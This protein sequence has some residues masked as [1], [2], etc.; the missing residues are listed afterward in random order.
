MKSAHLLLAALCV[1]LCAT[2]VH[3]QDQKEKPRTQWFQQAKWGVFMH[4]MGDTVCKDPTV[5][6]WNQAV[7]SFDVEGLADQLASA[8]A[9]YFVLTLGQNSGFFC[10]P[11]AAYDGFV[12]ITPSKCARRDL[13]A[14]L[15]AALKK[16]GIR[17]MVYLPAGAPDRDKEAMQK[18]EWQNGK[19]PFWNYKDGKPRGEDSRLV[20]FQQKWESVI[21]DWSKRWGGNVSGW[22]FDGCYFPDA[23]YRHPDAPNF[24]SFAAAARAGNPD[25]IVAFNPGVENPIITLTPAED[26]TAGEINAPD[27]VKCDGPRVGTAQLHMLSYLGPNW[28]QK[29]P[30]FTAEQTVQ[31]TRSITDKGGVV[32]WDVPPDGPT[33]KMLPEFLT[34]LQAIGKAL[35]TT[36]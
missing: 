17:L 25:S 2:T 19:F 33:G 11:N 26:Y 3:G 36:K 21:A 20:S 28:C 7:D 29:P 5:E 31:Y 8:G 14:D 4:Y 30:R 12:G 23:M 22:W 35:G 1:L 34:Q 15:A 9:G 16:R 6:T 32:T 24:E 27:K 18:L 13:P 10:A